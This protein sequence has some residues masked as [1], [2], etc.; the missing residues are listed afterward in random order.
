MVNGY[1]IAQLE[2]IQLNQSAQGIRLS[3]VE[4]TQAVINAALARKTVEVES[5]A[6]EAKGRADSAVQKNTGVLAVAAT[7]IGSIIASVITSL[8]IPRGGS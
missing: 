6:N 4:E 8:T 5:T 2:T 3:K 1:L 7:F